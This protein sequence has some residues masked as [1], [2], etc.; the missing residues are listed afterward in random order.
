MIRSPTHRVY[1]IF[2]GNRL[3]YV[4]RSIDE[5]SRL[6]AIQKRTGNDSLRV[7]VVFQTKNFKL[8]CLTERQMIRELRPT[9]NKRITSSPGN[10]GTKGSYSLGQTTRAKMS[11]AHLGHDVSEETRKKIG[12]KS[13]GRIPDS[14]SREKMR[15]S[16]LGKKASQ[17]TLKR[18]SA[19]QL[20]RWATFGRRKP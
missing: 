6:R 11:A 12:A 13:R 8:A 1:Q 19:A 18:M 7:I 9:L 14:E 16:H 2:D 17:E 5:Q 10:F 15:N 4:G 3:I 20:K